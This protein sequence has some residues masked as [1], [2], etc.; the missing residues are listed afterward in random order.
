M[1]EWVTEWKFL[2]R[3]WLFATPWTVAQQAPPSMEFSRQVYWSGCH[4]LLQGIFLTQGLNP[5]LLHLYHLSH[6]GSL[7]KRVT[8]FFIAFFLHVYI[9]AFLST[10][11]KNLFLKT[12]TNES[13]FFEIFFPNKNEYLFLWPLLIKYIWRL[14][15]IT[16]R[17]GDNTGVFAEDSSTLWLLFSYNY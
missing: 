14:L 9:L 2:S 16:Q 6:Q 11:N 1:S 10:I 8:V 12:R 4:F 3:V 5:G 13:K 15:Q 17:Y 7:K